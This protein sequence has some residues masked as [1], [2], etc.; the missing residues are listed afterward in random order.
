MLKGLLGW[1]LCLLTMSVTPAQGQKPVARK[2]EP[3]VMEYFYKVK[4]GYQDEFLRLFKKNHLPL[5][6][7]YMELG[8][9]VKLE[10]VKPADHMTEDGR[11]D[12]CMTITYRDI[13]AAFGDTSHHD[14]IRKQL[15]PD[16]A[17]FGREEQHR[18]ELLLAHWDVP[19]ETVDLNR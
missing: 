2:A 15:F 9:I 17:T 19:L 3:V 11:W 10:M 4:W 5:L 7:K 8:E 18:F 1:L 14:A 16:Q 6:R 13:D 12:F